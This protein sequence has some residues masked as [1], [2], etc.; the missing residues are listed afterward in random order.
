MSFTEKL[1][2]AWN[3]F[4]DPPNPPSNVGSWA[5]YG[6]S[7]RFLSFTGADRSFVNSIITRMAIDVASVEFLHARTDENGGYLETIPSGL[8]NC[9]NIEANT[10]QA[11]RAF[12]QDLA[13]TL[14]KKGV[15]AVVAVETDISPLKSG[16]FDIKSLRVGEI[17]NWYPQHVMVD[18][19][20]E[21]DGQ[22][23]QIT[24]PKSTVAIIENPLY[25]IMNEPNSMFQR[26]AKALRMMDGIEDDL[27]SKKLDV[28]VQLP[29]VVKG[30]N[31][32]QQAE[33]R[34]RDI[35]MQLR[36]TDFG[37]AYVDGTEKI[38]QLNR[39]V[40]SNILPRIE[41]LTKQVQAQLGLTTEILDGTAVETALLNY[42]NR[43]IKPV[44]DS[45]AEELAR[46]FLTKTARTQRQTVLYLRRPFDLVP[47]EKIADI[48]DKFT[49]NEI[50]SA[51]EVR[52]IIGM[53][54]S[55][56]PKADELYNANMPY[57]DTYPGGEEAEEEDMDP[58]AQPEEY[59]PEYDPDQYQ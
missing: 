28:I 31:R 15:A 40:E 5:Q 52:A 42:Q 8:Q 34:I 19:Y 51:N 24:L 45:I 20:D 41:W 26:L 47:M 10:D 36:K 32:R 48:A 33:N 22:H 58:Y 12:K 59:P 3:A 4:R 38:T 13:I 29:Y 6:P 50:L 21:R 49:R 43:I 35:E 23:K 44:A 30:E 9:L 57:D 7:R 1:K 46:T 27:S 53:R 55:T 25:D 39:A 14:F 56:D 54:P 16:G 2:H 17:V 11:A 18:L 37:I